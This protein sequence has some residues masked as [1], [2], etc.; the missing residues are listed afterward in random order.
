MIPLASTIEDMKELEKAIK[1]CNDI[2]AVKNVA[3]ILLE[4]GITY[5]SNGNK[6]EAVK[7]AYS[8][9]ADTHYTEELAT[10]YYNFKQLD[11]NVKDSATDSY[12]EEVEA[13]YKD[14]NVWDWLVLY[15]R[16]SLN[17]KDD[18]AIIK[19]CRMFLDN[20]F[21]VWEMV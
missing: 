9:L 7:Q 19:A 10:I 2:Q 11:S 4:E 6:L 3:T 17:T 1:T 5:L 14:I 18:E 21:S 20:G 15:G 13:T 16:M 8:E 12:T